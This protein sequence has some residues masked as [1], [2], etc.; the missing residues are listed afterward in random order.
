MVSRWFVCEPPLW[1]VLLWL[2]GTAEKGYSEKWSQ[3]NPRPV[4]YSLTILKGT[5]SEHP[6]GVNVPVAGFESGQ[7][8]VF[9][10]FFWIP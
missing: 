7:Y 10:P 1:L 4:D 5:Y 6:C 9:A 2:A 8:G 3:A